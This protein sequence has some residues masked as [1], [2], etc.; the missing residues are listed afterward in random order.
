M[1]VGKRV[2]RARRAAA[3]LIAFAVIGVAILAGLALFAERSP[4]NSNDL[5]FEAAGEVGVDPFV[6]DLRR[7]T[8]VARTPAV[9]PYAGEVSGTEPGLWEPAGQEDC[10]TEMLV[11]T[12]ADDPERA[13]VWASIADVAPENI[14][15]FVDALRPVTLVQDV[16]VLNHGYAGGKATPIRT[17]LQAGT[18]VMVN[19]KGVPAVLCK[20]GNPLLT[21]NPDLTAEPAGNGWPTYNPSRVLSLIAVMPAMPTPVPTPTATPTP[22]P[23]STPVPQVPSAP[24]PTPPPSATPTPSPTATAAPTVPPT[25]SPTPTTAATATPQP[26]ST[27]VPAP[28]TIGCVGVAVDS[29][30]QLILTVDL[31]WTP[32]DQEI[33]IAVD[34]AGTS[35]PQRFVDTAHVRGDP[36]SIAYTLPGDTQSR[37]V[38]CPVR[39]E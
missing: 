11:S 13:A 38:T 28:F 3:L 32:V 23:T 16:I 7:V 39:Y 37:L 9:V 18:L 29:Q 31:S 22:I 35:S 12:L 14:G 33:N 17:I 34:G 4:T 30:E 2:T 24:T 20:C 5:R 8:E 21:A 26:T 1:I 15:S 25:P 19:A 36:V 10:D 6:S 27:P